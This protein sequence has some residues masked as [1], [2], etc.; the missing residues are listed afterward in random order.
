VMP[1]TAPL[2][3]PDF[4]SLNVTLP[5]E[6]GLADVLDLAAAGGLIGWLAS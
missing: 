4:S 6:A 2:G 5:N 1:N 3:K